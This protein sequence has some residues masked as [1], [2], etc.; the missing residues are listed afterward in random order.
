M[1]GLTYL[2]LDHRTAPVHVRECLSLSVE[3]VSGLLRDLCNASGEFADM[4]VPEAIWLGTCNRVELYALTHAPSPERALDHLEG[5]LT[6]SSGLPSD[7]LSPHLQRGHGPAVAEHLCRVAAGIDSMILGE[8]QILGQV[9]CAHRLALEAGTVGPVLDALFR[10]AIECGK[11]ARTDT[12]IGNNAASVGYAA[13]ELAAKTLG[14]LGGRRVLLIGAGEM[15]QAAASNLCR[16]NVLELLVVNRTYERAL[17][18]AQRLGGKAM[19]WDSLS[20]ALAR[21]DVVLCSVAAPQVV[22]GRD[23]MQGVVSQRADRPLLL[24]DIGVPRN[25]DPDVAGLDGVHLYDIDD[26]AHVVEDNLA[27]REAHVPHVEALVAGAV[28]EF[29]AWLASREVA[30]TIR[31]L[32]D[33]AQSICDAQVLQAL[34]RLGPLGDREE[35]IIRSLGQAIANKLLHEPTVQLKHFAQNGQGVQYAQAVR[36]LFGLA[37]TPPGETHTGHPIA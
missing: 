20:V 3:D 34:Q 1:S 23:M 16:S 33:M 10:K 15:A 19:P 22:V 32:H 35:E 29:A 31:D 9:G 17:E 36:D 24:I 5:F 21:A 6:H 27:E 14:T 25:V 26:L 28:D 2:G 13:V 37:S 18:L 8:A 12:A 7:T 30:P 4:H 11:R